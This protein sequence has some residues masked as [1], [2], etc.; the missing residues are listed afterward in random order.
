VKNVRTR[1]ATGAT[2]VALGGL[3]GLALSAGGK[4]PAATSVADMPQVRTKVIRRTIHVTKHAKPRHPGPSSSGFSSSYSSTPV[5]TSASGAA[6]SESA[7]SEPVVTSTSGG[8]SAPS[9][10]VTT[11]SSGGGAEGGGVEVEHE[12]E[13]GDD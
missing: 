9:A 10:P 4:G 13:G 6:S 7:G 3:T 1:V 12:S 8:G 5:K 11:G 2:V